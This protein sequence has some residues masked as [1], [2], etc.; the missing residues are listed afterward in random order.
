MIF[1]K[2]QSIFYTLNDFLYNEIYFKI[3]IILNL[4]KAFPYLLWIWWK[5]ERECQRFEFVFSIPFRLCFFLLLPNNLSKCEKHE[6]VREHSRNWFPFLRRLIDDGLRLRRRPNTENFQSRRRRKKKRSYFIR[7]TNF[8]PF[9]S[10]CW[11]LS[12]IFFCLF[13]ATQSML[14]CI[15]LYSGL[16]LLLLRKSFFF[17][18]FLFLLIRLTEVWA[19]AGLNC[20]AYCI[21]NV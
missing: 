14:V 13:V 8:S 11:R 9:R 3:A 4:I 16:F 6:I 17:F 1:L 10:L 19:F 12:F 18:L 2:I 5:G 20:S 7:K 15:S 21:L